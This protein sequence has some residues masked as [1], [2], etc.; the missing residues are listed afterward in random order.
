MK[1]KV[2]ELYDNPKSRGF[3]NHLIKSY[4]PSSKIQKVW[5]F[6]KGQKEA[7]NVC[8]QKLGAIGPMMKYLD[9]NKADLM[10]S[11]T[12]QLRKEVN[13]EEVKREDNIYV[14]ALGKDK[15][16]GMTAEKTDT[17]LCH[18]CCVDLLELTQNGLLMGD[19]NLTYQ[20][21]QMQRD[22][23]F[24]RF[25]ESPAIDDEDKAKVKEIK[26]KVNKDRKITT[27]GDL[28]A[29]QDLKQK[30]EENN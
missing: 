17:C 4:L 5:N 8:G 13:G 26:K 14:K 3:V 1:T 20:I 24:D 6:E 2:Q 25:D 9:E 10:K 29:L 21:N 18:Q 28:Q 16:L 22:Q 19:K 11:F 12:L 7:C 30:M 27:F 15:V 23:I